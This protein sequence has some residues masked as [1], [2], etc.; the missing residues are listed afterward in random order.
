[1][2]SHLLKKNPSRKDFIWTPPFNVYRVICS[3]KATAVFYWVLEKTSQ[4]RYTSSRDLMVA[5]LSFSWS[6][7][8][9]C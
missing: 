8:V 1:V 3:F 2:Y 7:F 6:A 4:E 5:D 9:N